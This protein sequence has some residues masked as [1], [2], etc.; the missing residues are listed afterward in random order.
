MAYDLTLLRSYVRFYLTVADQL[1]SAWGSLARTH[2]AV[3]S[4][5]APFNESLGPA[6]SPALAAALAPGRPAPEEVEGLWRPADAEGLGGLADVYE[7]V[8]RFSCQG[9]GGEN[10]ARV[11]WL[12]SNARNEIHA[13][14]TR[15]GDLAQLA[16]AARAAA[17][18]L[19]ADEARTGE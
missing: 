18:R 4:A 1:G 9:E 6:E 14:R 16:P 17:E 13:Q 15:L 10:R 3:R 7:V 11:Q 12:V 5:L 8:G 2:E 19:A